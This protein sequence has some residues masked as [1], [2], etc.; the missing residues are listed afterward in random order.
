MNNEERSSIF[1]KLSLMEVPKQ[2]IRLPTGPLKTRIHRD[3]GW[4]QPGGGG[5]SW[6][7]GSDP[8]ALPPHPP[9]SAPTPLPQPCFRFFFQ[10]QRHEG[11]LHHPGPCLSLPY[12]FRS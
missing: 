9:Q 7:P 4:E 8:S 6:H 1:L 5:A 11:L 10:A 3:W 12:L 2:H